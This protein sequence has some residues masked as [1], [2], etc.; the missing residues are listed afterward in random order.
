LTESVKQQRSIGISHQKI[1][2][3]YSRAE[4]IVLRLN[5]EDYYLELDANRI[6]HLDDH[7]GQDKD[8][9]NIPLTEKQ[10][11]QI[12]E[13]V[14][15]FDDLIDVI[16][17]KDGSVRLMLGKKING[18]SIIVE[19][20][21]KGR[22][23]LHPVTAYQIDTNDYINKY[24]T[25]AIDRS[26]TSRPANADTVDISRPAIAPVNTSIPNV[27]KNVKGYDIAP[28]MP[29]I[30]PPIPENVRRKPSKAPAQVGDTSA[31]IWL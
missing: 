6:A 30:A 15:D 2:D 24:K 7:V 10:V 12:P 9:R 11:E 1:C 8:I 13:Y 22:S 31:K 19:T 21:S 27:G 14:D 26:S 23:S 5:I 29:D 20:V 28:P 16:R 25:R 17:R 3:T 18:H 4:G